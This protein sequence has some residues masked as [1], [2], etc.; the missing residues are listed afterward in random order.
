VL[1]KYLEDVVGTTT[2]VSPLYEENTIK[3]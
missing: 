2:S 3:I 1:I